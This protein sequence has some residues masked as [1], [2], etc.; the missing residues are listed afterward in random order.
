MTFDD[1]CAIL[2][3]EPF[4][5][6]FEEI[7]R[8]TYYQITEILGRAVGEDGRVELKGPRRPPATL[9][10]PQS[11]FAH[12]MRIRLKGDGTPYTD[13]E[14]AEAWAAERLRAEGRAA[15]AGEPG[16]GPLVNNGGGATDGG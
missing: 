1:L 13:H 2:T 3:H 7:A 15:A 10:D 5:Y 9:T 8:L 12:S 16:R 11:I 14:I 6:R 4:L